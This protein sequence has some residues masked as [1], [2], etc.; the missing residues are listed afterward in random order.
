MAKLTAESYYEFGRFRLK[1]KDRVLECEGK[2]VRLHDQWYDILLILVRRRRIVT[3]KELIEAIW[4]DD[5]V[6]RR[7]N[8]HVNITELR[9]A[10]RAADPSS[11][12]LIKNQ[13]RKGYSLAAE[14]TEH[15]IP[16]TIAVLPFKVEGAPEE[17][18]ESGLKLADKLTVTLNGHTSISVRST[19]SVIKKYSLHPNQRPLIFGHHLEADY[20]LFGRILR[21][22]AVIE[23]EAL[24]VRADEVMATASFEEW[25]PAVHRLI[26]EWMVSLLGLPPAPRREDELAKRYTSNPV[27]NK[28]YTDGRVQRFRSTEGS[29][30]RAAGLFRK[31][32]RADPDFAEAYV[33][34]AGT[35]IFRGML[36]LIPPLDS[37]KGAR[38][39]ART[40]LEK[41]PRLAGAYSTWAFIKLFFERKWDEAQAGFERAI[42]IKEN[43]PAAHMGKAH[44]LTARGRHAEALKEIDAALEDPY[45]FFLNFVLGMALFMAREFEKCLKQFEWTQY[46]NLQRFKIKSDLPYYGMS[47]AQEY[48]ALGRE[49]D[50]RE[51]L[52]EKADENAVFA[53]R[54][55]KGNT[56]KL[57]HRCQLLA[58]WGKR[59]EAERLLNEALE[60]RQS[61][62]YVYHLGIAYAA[63]G[64]VDKAIASLEEGPGVMD[65]YLFLTGVDPRLDSLRS[66]PRFKELFRRLG[67][68]D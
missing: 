68:E 53:I 48:C 23:V 1:P 44:C 58:M 29:L 25:R 55:S 51:G 10:L 21:E 24:D 16:T 64:D 41:N 6:D 9:N 12:D 40:A 47:L 46:L 50:E 13:K 59:D 34:I 61:G 37:Y 7:P 39:A 56:L 43:Y 67:L 45:S 3:T 2:A 54:I 52:F 20:V 4:P 17:T 15:E 33:G 42:E 14:V 22:Q 32:A 31:A 28:Y 65:Q 38:E 8:L 35:N 63:L 62:H 27:A 49:G 26:H 66:D 19:D 60:Q 5:V 11:P 18:D 30:R 57:L 36:G